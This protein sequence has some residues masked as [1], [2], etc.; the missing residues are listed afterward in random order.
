[1]MLNFCINIFPRASIFFAIKIR[2]KGHGGV[3]VGDIEDF[4]ETL[5]KFGVTK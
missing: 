4:V 3:L 1:M 2:Q 5:L